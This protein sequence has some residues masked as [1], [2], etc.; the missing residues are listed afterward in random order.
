MALDDMP[1]EEQEKLIR[2]LAEDPVYFIEVFLDRQLSP[3]QKIFLEETK[4][5]NHVV[6]IWSRQTGKST[7]IASY[8][9]W[10]LLYGTG[11]LVHNEQVPEKIAICAPIKDQLDNLYIKMRSLID[12]SEFISSYVVKMNSEQII[13]KNNNQAKLMSASPGSHIRGYTA[14]C[15]V[16]DETQDVTD[17]KYNADILPFGATT[18]ALIIEAGTPKTKNHFFTTINSKNTT[19]IRQKWFECPFLS[20]EYVMTQKDNSPDALWRQEYLCEFIEEGVLAFPSWLFEPEKDKKTEK[21]TGRWNLGDYKYITKV[22]ELTQKIVEKIAENI[23]DGA[24]FVAGVD[25]GKSQDNSVLVIYRTDIR[26]IRLEAE[27]VF[28]LD[29]PYLKL[30]KQISMFYAA[31]QPYEI[32]V[33]YTNEKMF[34]EELQANDVPVIVDPKKKR[35]A[36]AFTNANKDEMIGNTRM[37]LERYQFQLPKTAEKLISQFLNQQFEIFN[38]NKRKYYHPSNEHDDSLWATLLAL[39]NISIM[40]VDDVT[41]FVNPWEKHDDEIRPME[42]SVN[43]KLHDHSKLRRTKG[44]ANS[45]TKRLDVER[46]MTRHRLR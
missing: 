46:T 36:I 25:L 3:K 40:S 4:T 19:V 16:I 13:M 21:L 45:W 44:Y 5:K 11:K 32:N 18:N 22:E 28:P 39:K 7:V 26:P 38:E 34:I 9:I 30:A 10:R 20:K 35:G 2:K 29:T 27:L 33:D 6:A 23:N 14:T 41:T 37:L 17:D 42:D 12:K 15:I 43:V 8:I 1:V 31:F 24:R